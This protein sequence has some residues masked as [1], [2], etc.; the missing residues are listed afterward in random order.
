MRHAHRALDQTYIARRNAMLPRQDTDRRQLLGTI[1]RCLRTIGRTQGRNSP[2]N[3]TDT[4][5]NQR[6]STSSDG[7]NTAAG[8]TYSESFYSTINDLITRYSDNR[9]EDT[10]SQPSTSRDRAQNRDALSSNNDNSD[11]DPDDP[12]EPDWF[13]HRSASS[14]SPRNNSSLYRTNNV[15]LVP[16]PPV[17]PPPSSPSRPWNVP[18]VQVNDVPVTE[19]SVFAQRLLS[20]RQRFAERV[21]ELR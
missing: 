1:N 16:Q 11:D 9:E 2:G 10:P 13:Y 7:G 12:E 5:A 15:N 19:P 17:E 8:E 6:P 21:S 20:H 4:A 14:N 18:S 3:N